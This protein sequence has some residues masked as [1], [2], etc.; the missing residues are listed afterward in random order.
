MRWFLVL[1]ALA[2]SGAATAHPLP[3]NAADQGIYCTT[4]IGEFVQRWIKQNPH[5]SN[6]ESTEIAL[7]VERR[8]DLFGLYSQY[9]DPHFISFAQQDME[10]CKPGHNSPVCGFVRHYCFGVD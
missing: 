6:Q 3:D 10:I 8:L 7:E 2:S 5:R 9:G 4:V 1:I